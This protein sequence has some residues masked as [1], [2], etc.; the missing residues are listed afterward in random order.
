YPW[1]SRMR[2]P[3]HGTSLPLRSLHGVM[4]LLRSS[5][6]P[7]TNPV[8][9]ARTGVFVL[10]LL[11]SI[12]DLGPASFHLCGAAV[13]IMLLRFLSH[14]HLYSLDPEGGGWLPRTMVTVR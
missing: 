3:L 9:I 4:E 12:P 6:I 11:K 7:T 2:T 13:K 10:P 1:S 5:Y 14:G 8:F